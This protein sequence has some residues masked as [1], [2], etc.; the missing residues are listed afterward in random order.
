MCL[1]INECGSFSL[2]IDF[3]L[4]FMFFLA[5]TY[6]RL[7]TIDSKK[8]RELNKQVLETRIDMNNTKSSPTT[9]PNPFKRVFQNNSRKVLNFITQKPIECKPQVI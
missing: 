6:K 5:S 4:F 9:L 7:Y 1:R 3:A 8:V 2:F